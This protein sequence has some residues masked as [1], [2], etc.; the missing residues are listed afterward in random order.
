M[1]KESSFS[2]EKEAKRLFDLAPRSSHGGRG[3]MWEVFLLLFVHKKK[4]FPS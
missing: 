3:A 1:N 4:D 2:E